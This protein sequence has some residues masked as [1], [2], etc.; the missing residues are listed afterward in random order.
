MQLLRFAHIYYSILCDY[1]RTNYN[2]YFIGDNDDF[3]IYYTTAYI[4]ILYFKP[5]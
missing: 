2:T 1:N 3:H 4:F 5:L